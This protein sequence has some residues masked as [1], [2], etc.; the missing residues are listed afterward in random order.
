[1]KSKSTN[2]HFAL[3]WM[4]GC[5]YNHVLCENVQTMFISV[6]CSKFASKM[7]TTFQ[8]IIP[9]TK[10][11][12]HLIPDEKQMLINPQRYSTSSRRGQG[13]LSVTN[14]IKSHP[15][16][17]S[18]RA[19]T[20]TLGWSKWKCQRV[21]RINPV[22]T[23]C[24]ELHSNLFSYVSLDKTDVHVG[25]SKW[26]SFTALGHGWWGTYEHLHYVYRYMHSAYT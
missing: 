14:N 17:I 25:L 20:S 24:T 18:F 21:V 11:N 13:E 15:V 9:W 8:Y 10:P 3:L 16:D 19:K 6:N 7:W 4:S 12:L 2:Y 22:G 26:S 5:G 1:M 23:V